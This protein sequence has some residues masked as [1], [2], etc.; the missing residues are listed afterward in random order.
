MQYLAVIIVAVLVFGVCYLF[1]KGF[2]KL[3]R[4]QAQHHSGLSVRV[5]KRYAAFGAILIA[6]GFAA[7][8]AGLSDGWLLTAGGVMILVIGICLIVYYATFG[9]FYDGESFVLTTFGKK[10]TTYRY[11]DI[12]TQQL[13]TVSGNTVIELHMT[14]CRSVSLQA[15]MIGVYDFLDTAFDGW[16][17]QKS[18]RKEDCP[19]HDP[20]NSCWFPC[21]EEQ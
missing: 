7:V 9:I 10:S 6:L 3:F 11:L 19:F 14:D 4:N 13:Y 12:K 1:D 18:I 21:A 17:R 20:A 5:N 15:G 16:C 2:Q 8:F